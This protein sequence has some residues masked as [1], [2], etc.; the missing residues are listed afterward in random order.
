M[1]FV[2]DAYF[3]D[4]VPLGGA[5]L[6]LAL[7]TSRRRFWTNER[8]RSSFTTRWRSFTTARG[9]A[10]QT[11]TQ[12]DERAAVENQ[13]LRPEETSQETTMKRSCCWR[14]E[15]LRRWQSKYP[16]RSL[17]KV[18]NLHWRTTYFTHG[19]DKLSAGD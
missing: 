6:F 12:E 10:F 13:R 4:K 18:S 8:W 3:L 7:N 16:E 1:L 14:N 17:L 19:C 5:P 2:S 9:E 11:T 15:R